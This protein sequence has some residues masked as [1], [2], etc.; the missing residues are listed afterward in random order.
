MKE[1]EENPEEIKENEFKNETK[2]D[3][4]N[5]NNDINTTEK[6]YII[7]HDKT[8]IEVSD[9]KWNRFLIPYKSIL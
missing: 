4:I 7:C 6:Q 9:K 2:E 1:K 3:N 8:I 5:I